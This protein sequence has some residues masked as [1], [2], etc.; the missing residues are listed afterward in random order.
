MN[1]CTLTGSSAASSSP[2]PGSTRKPTSCCVRRDVSSALP[3]RPLAADRSDCVD[4]R[5]PPSRS[6]LACASISGRVRCGLGMAKLSCKQRPKWSKEPVGSRAHEESWGG[7][8]MRRV[9][10]HESPV[11]LQCSKEAAAQAGP[12][13]CQ[14]SNSHTQH[15]A[16]RQSCH[17]TA[18]DRTPVICRWR[19]K[20]VW[21]KTSQRWLAQRSMY[22]GA[23]RCA[24]PRTVLLYGSPI[25]TWH[26]QSLFAVKRLDRQPDEGQAPRPNET[27]PYKSMKAKSAT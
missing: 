17:P 24:Q 18:G 6:C 4:T 26:S 7:A 23:H 22:A 1:S 9:V 19:V 11:L 12:R 3:S 10:L 21:V 2:W 25:H 13:C 5:P 14:P 15:P 16:R 27:R 20:Q 8:V